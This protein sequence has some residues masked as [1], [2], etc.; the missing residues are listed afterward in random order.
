[1]VRIECEGLWG[2]LRKEANLPITPVTTWKLLDDQWAYS[3]P[4]PHLWPLPFPLTLGCLAP[5]HFYRS[6]SET[7]EALGSAAFFK[8]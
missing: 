3:V 2:Q 8:N 5:N 7:C 4:I 6:V 1:M